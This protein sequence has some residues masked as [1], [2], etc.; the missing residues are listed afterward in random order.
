MFYSL[1]QPIFLVLEFHWLDHSIFETTRN[2]QRNFNTTNGSK[3]D[4]I[5][6]LF[7]KFYWGGNFNDDLGCPRAEITNQMLKSFS[8]WSNSGL[9][10]TFDV[11]QHCNTNLHIVSC[12]TASTCFHTEFTLANSL[13]L[14]LACEMIANAMLQNL[15]AGEIGVGNICF[16]AEAY[17]FFERIRQ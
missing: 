4:T 15:D 6:A 10:F 8:K 14:L 11:L 7:E 1:E 5:E 17:F 3:R 16:F 12:T 13:V 9:A 2:F